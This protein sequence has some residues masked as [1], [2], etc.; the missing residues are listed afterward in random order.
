[1]KRAGL[2]A[3]AERQQKLLATRD[4][5]DRINRFVSWEKF[6]P[7]LDKALQRSTGEAGGR[8]AYDTVLMFKVLVLQAL[9]NMSDEQTEYQ[10]LDRQSFMMFLGLDIQD[11]VPDA[12]NDSE[13]IWADSAYRSEDQEDRLK[14]K[15]YRSHIHERAYRGKPLTEEQQAANT[16]RSRVRVRVEHVF[17]HIQTAMNGCYVRTIGKVRAQAKIGLENIAYNISRFT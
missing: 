1:M 13:D 4:F 17:G 10:I 8:P 7:M 14:A 5:L 16:E 12:R 9:Y 3:R 6:R 2:Y 11:S 15:G